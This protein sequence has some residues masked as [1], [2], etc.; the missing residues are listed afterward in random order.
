VGWSCF[1]RGGEA[2]LVTLHFTHR[3][4]L[5]GA[6]CTGNRWWWLLAGAAGGGRRSSEVGRVEKDRLTVGGEEI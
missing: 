5:D 3:K 1:G 4:Q 2:A 6:T